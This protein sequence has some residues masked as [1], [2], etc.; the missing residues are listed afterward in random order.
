MADMQMSN[1]AA[2]IG[3]ASTMKKYNDIPIDVL[4]DD[5]FARL[6]KPGQRTLK[7]KEL[8]E[9]TRQYDTSLQESKRASQVAEALDR[10][11]LDET[12]RSNKADESYKWAALNKSGGSGSSISSADKLNG[13]RAAAIDFAQRQMKVIPYNDEAPYKAVLATKQLLNSQ[14]AQ[15]NLT[16]SQ[17]DDII[18][19]VSTAVGYQEQ[20]ENSAD[21]ASFLNMVN[22]LK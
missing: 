22:S 14:L 21:N 18:K 8:D 16:Q 5:S 6:Y 3:Q 12:I 17:Y 15:L 11:K 13:I 19:T 7:S 2:Q 1:T 20:D 9:N 10:A 4:P